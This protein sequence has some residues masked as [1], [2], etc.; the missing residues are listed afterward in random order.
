MKLTKDGIYQRK[1]GEAF[2]EPG[3]RGASFEQ[4]VALQRNPDSDGRKTGGRSLKEEGGCRKKIPYG[5]P[6]R[7]GEHVSTKKKR[8]SD[9]REKVP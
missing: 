2:W 9:S 8:P 6:H 7:R 3:K 5:K 1:G 4:I